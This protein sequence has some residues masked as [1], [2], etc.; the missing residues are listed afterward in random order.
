MSHPP[1]I[2]RD[3]DDDDNPAADEFARALGEFEGGSGPAAMTARAARSIVVGMKVRGTVVAIGAE[4]ALL[5]IGARSEGV[6]DLTQFRNEDGSLRIAVGEAFDLFVV[7][8]GDQLVL[9]PSLR[10]DAGSALR[11]IREA[12]AAGVPVTGRVTALNGGGLEVDFAGARGF[13]PMSQIEAGYCADPSTYVGRTLE[14]LVTGF[15]DTR[16]SFVL[17]RRQFLRRAEEEETRRRL[18]ALKAG[19]EV[20]G[21]VA[22]LEAF[23]AFVNLGGVVGL[24]HVSEIQHGRVSHPRDVLREG[25]KVRARVLRIEAGKDGRP[26]IALS[27]KASAP[28]PWADLP[29]RLAP[30]MRV[31]GTVARLADFGAFVTLAPGIDGLVHLSEIAS[32]R[33]ERVKDALAVGQEIEVTV[34]A[35]DAA[36]QRI[37]LSIR[38]TLAAEEQPVVAGGLGG[39]STAAPEAAPADAPS[40]EP[41]DPPLTTMAI[42][43][44]EAAEKARRKQAHPS[45]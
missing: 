44:R 10:A 14:F 11:Q 8:A 19:D 20:D 31:K 23:G 3:P 21:T 24:V 1:A 25:D 9:A 27:I 36:K 6:A 42:A 22:R 41:T 33:I 12:H 37:S 5:D 35:V 28:D 17:S 26:R 32:R 15:E 43:L 18:A 38:A 40:V 34:L 16:R 30:G 29:Q 13:C 7:E 39:R 45:S 4:H 2:I